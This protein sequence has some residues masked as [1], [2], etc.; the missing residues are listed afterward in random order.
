MDYLQAAKEVVPEFEQYEKLVK[1]CNEVITNGM[2]AL[3][4]MQQNEEAAPQEGP[5]PEQMK[6]D[7]EIELKRMKTEDEI[8]LAK[9]KQDAEI[10]RNAV[11]ANAK[12]AQSLGGAR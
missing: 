11:E 6:A 9:E 2:R 7:A 1:R 12:A 5:T 8:Q 3:E 4:A 10:T